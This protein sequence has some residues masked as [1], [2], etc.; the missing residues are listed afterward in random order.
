M[1]LKRNIT[2]YPITLFLLYS[3]FLF[4]F[5]SITES[6]AYVKGIFAKS[7]FRF[8]VYDCFFTYV[9]FLLHV[10][11]VR[12]VEFLVGSH[13]F[14]T[15]LMNSLFFIFFQR[16]AFAYFLDS[17]NGCIMLMSIFTVLYHRIVPRVRASSIML[18]KGICIS[19]EVLLWLLTFF[20]S[21]S[22]RLSGVIEL[23]VGILFANFILFP[24]LQKQR[25]VPFPSIITN[26]I[27]YC[28]SSSEEPRDRNISEDSSSPF[29]LDAGFFGRGLGSSVESGPPHTV[30][31]AHIE[32]LMGL[33][34]S[35]YECEHALLACDNDVNRAADYLLSSV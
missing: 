22:S 7:I 13:R 12:K 3:V 35:R 26:F 21:L 16:W 27:I 9:V 14:M 17:T 30:S 1:A 24:L 18:Y 25:L 29:M 33:G 34:F 11:L 19:E 23:F 4:S 8:L 15:L 5:L 2:A 6:E 31:Q 20:V 10:Y 32:E 28:A